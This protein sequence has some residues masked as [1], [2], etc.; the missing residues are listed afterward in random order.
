MAVLPGARLLGRRAKP[1]HHPGPRTPPSSSNSSARLYPAADG[2]AEDDT[3]P[4]HTEERLERRRVLSR[5]AFDVFR[6]WR[7]T[8]G[9][10]PDGQLDTAALSAWID[11]ARA[12]LRTANLLSDSDAEIGRALAHLP[13]DPDGTSPRTAV[14]D[15]MEAAGSDDLERGLGRRHPRAPHH[16]KPKHL[17][18]RCAGTDTGR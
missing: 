12:R 14:R 2:D 17:R 6:S 4:A 7:R 8:P 13:A 1:S 16:D 9:V 11:E 15:L 5:Q 10:G 18:G 3:D